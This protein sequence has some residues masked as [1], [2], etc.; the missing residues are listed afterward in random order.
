MTQT[1]PIYLTTQELAELLRIKERKIYDMA[2]SGQVP[3]IRV[4]GKLL[5]PR[6]EIERWIQSGRSGPEASAPLPGIMVGS[7]D[8]LLEWALR[9]SG[10]GIAGLFDGSFDG[11][12]RFA[13]REAMA[14][15]LHIHEA[16]GGWNVQTVADA[17]GA[18]PVVLVRLMSRRRGLLVAARNPL[19]I[20]GIADLDPH[21]V[22]RRQEMAA[23]ERHFQNLVRAADLDPDAMR[24]PRAPA[25]S[26]LDLARAVADG[27]A[28][29]A[30]GV[31]AV[32]KPFGLDFI[33]IV[34]ES[35]DLL[36]WRQAWFE[37]Q[38]QALF[39]LIHSGRFA[40]RAGELGGYDV[41][42]AL[43]VRLN[44]SAP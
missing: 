16:D 44:G 8:P 3:C 25:R 6:Q 39:G 27:Q 36:V 13:R 18:Q 34:E 43:Q 24:G 32:A 35:F 28:D 20:T 2:A 31:K 42:E 17:V 37:P 41:A 33:D 1:D 4:V 12:E 15:A 38:M 23:S 22:V 30:F 19:G 9:D 11:L 5:F 21:R 7:H 26:E 10:S 40:I 14:C 29:A